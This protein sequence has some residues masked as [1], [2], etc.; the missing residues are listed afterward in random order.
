MIFQ[1]TQETRHSTAYLLLQKGGHDQLKRWCRRFL[2]V[3]IVLVEGGNEVFR[4]NGAY[5]QRIGDG[6]PQRARRRSLYIEVEKVLRDGRLFQCGQERHRMGTGRNQPVVRIA[7]DLRKG[8][9]KV[10][11]LPSVGS[12][13]QRSGI[14]SC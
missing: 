13:D 12:R 8:S 10:L 6:L 1:V 7:S 9:P 14:Q 11:R 5:T 3:V 2:K 4:P